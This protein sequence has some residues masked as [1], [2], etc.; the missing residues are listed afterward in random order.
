MIHGRATI[1]LLAALS[2]AATGEVLGPMARTQQVLHRSHEIVVGPDDHRHKVLALNELLRTFLDT[3]AMGRK[4][5]GRHL[6]GRPPGEV[7]AF[8]DVFHQLFVRTYVQR[9]LLFEAPEFAYRQEAIT[10]EQATVGTDIVTPKDRFAV[11][12]LMRRAAD[13]WHATDILVEDVSLAD[14]FR[15]Q[16]DAALAKESFDSLMGRLQAKAGAPEEPAL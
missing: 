6:D 4:A 13:G 8:L 11:D 5:M 3:D 14:N 7:R 9:L 1:V 16:F 10:A 15:S 2:A 12:Y